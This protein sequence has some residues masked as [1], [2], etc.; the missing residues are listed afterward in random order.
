MYKRKV[1][2]L[3]VGSSDGARRA[4]VCA[5]R[6]G[7]DWIE[8]RALDEP[9]EE[10]LRWADL[11]ITLGA[12]PSLTAPLPPHVQYRH[13]ALTDADVP[14]IERRVQGIVGGL[15]MFA[16]PPA[17]ASSETAPNDR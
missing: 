4:A 1:R 8:P 5:R 10:D 13:W 2:V 15:R 7:G 9:A 14:A 11:L 17:S 6:L 3:F 12:V 16:G